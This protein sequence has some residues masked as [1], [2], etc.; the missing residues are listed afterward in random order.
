MTV[1]MEAKDRAGEC[2]PKNP[3]TASGVIPPR[4]MR[5]P[6]YGSRIAATRIGPSGASIMSR[7]SRAIGDVTRPRRGFF[8]RRRRHRRVRAGHYER[9]RAV[10]VVVY[11]I[12]W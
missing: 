7:D 4:W 11:H 1:H 8:L 5:R 2:H 10:V 3:P 6:W 12:R 9:I